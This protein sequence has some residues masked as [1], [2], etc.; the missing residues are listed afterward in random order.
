MKKLVLKILAINIFCLL[1]LSTVGSTQN[2]GDLKFPKVINSKIELSLSQL[3]NNAKMNY[4]KIETLMNWLSRKIEEKAND[5]FI[6]SVQIL[7][8]SGGEKIER[9]FKI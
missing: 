8:T 5:Y 2:D 9:S 1:V 6:R 3:L 4:E 7:L